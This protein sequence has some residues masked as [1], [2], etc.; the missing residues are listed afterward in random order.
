[1][2]QHV[3]LVAFCSI[4]QQVVYSRRHSQDIVQFADFLRDQIV[5]NREFPLPFPQ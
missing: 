3:L 4:E 2:V 1:M 5:L